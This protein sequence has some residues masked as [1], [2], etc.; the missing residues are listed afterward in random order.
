MTLKSLEYIA[1][2]CLRIMWLGLYLNT[3]QSDPAAIRP[4]NPPTPYIPFL[5]IRKLNLGLSRVRPEDGS[6]IAIWLAGLLPQKHMSVVSHLVG[7][8]LDAEVLSVGPRA[9]EAKAQWKMVY[10]TVRHL[11]AHQALMTDDRVASLMARLRDLG[12]LV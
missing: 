12:E 7:P 11:R 3:N 5:K 10:E 1:K 9:E 6:V 4:A 2:H 8:R